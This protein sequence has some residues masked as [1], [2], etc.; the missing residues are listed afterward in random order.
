MNSNNT[1]EIL[2]KTHEFVAAEFSKNSE[3]IMDGMD[4]AICSLQGKRLTYSGAKRPLWICRNG[5]I[6]EI[7]GTA[8][9]ISKEPLTKDFELHTV[10]LIEGDMVYLFTN[11]IIHQ[12][13]GEEG[14][15]LKIS[16]LKRLIEAIC[17]YD[18]S[19]QKDM[20]QKGFEDWRGNLE[21]I[22][23]ICILG[24]KVGQ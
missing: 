17:S 6:M 24:F 19:K 23:D 2:T 4:I 18:P 1:K 15:K 20:L 12:F 5:E 22:D 11:G 21:Q 14:K 3:Y 9:S 16:N 7:N 10:D 13:G 8:T